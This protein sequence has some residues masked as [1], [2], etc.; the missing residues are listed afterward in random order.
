MVFEKKILEKLLIAFS[1]LVYGIDARA[2]IHV[3]G[4]S[5]SFFCFTDS[6]MQMP[7]LLDEPFDY[8]YTNAGYRFRV[9]F[10]IHCFIA[11][12]LH[13]VGREGVNAINVKHM[14]IAERD[15]VIFCFGEV[16]VRHH[17]GRQRDFHGRNLYEILYTL[18]NNYIRF[19]EQNRSF[20]KQLNCMIFGVVPP[21][22]YSKFMPPNFTPDTAFPFYGT[23]EDRVFITR[24][25]N[26]IMKEEGAKKNI[27]FLD[28]G[29]LYATPQGVLNP[30]FFDGIVHIQPQ[31][32][33]PI[34][35]RLLPILIGQNQFWHHVKG[36]V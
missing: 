10:H 14:G 36:L 7:P 11:R 26:R 20:Y 33:R 21:L 18:T 30:I 17:I 12:T 35:E 31:F 25:L 15:T 4:D 22:A 29:D 28:I 16:D 2:V 9:P 19:I 24:E 27:G 8:I 32:N 3:I 6:P 5:H 13:R 1:A 34:K 23:P